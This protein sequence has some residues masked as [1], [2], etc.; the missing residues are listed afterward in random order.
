MALARHMLLSANQKNAEKRSAGRVL[1]MT[2]PN[3]TVRNSQSFACSPPKLLTYNPSSS[4]GDFKRICGEKLGIVCTRIF[5]LSGG[6]VDTCQQLEKDDVLICTSGEVFIAPTVKTFDTNIRAAQVQQEQLQQLQQQQQQQQQQQ[7]QLLLRQRNHSPPQGG[8]LVGALRGGGTGVAAPKAKPSNA[9][10]RFKSVVRRVQNQKQINGRHLGTT[11]R[12][13]MQHQHHPSTSVVPTSMIATSSNSN[14]NQSSSNQS[15]SNSTQGNH[16]MDI[17]T[18]HENNE[19]ASPNSNKNDS[20]FSSSK[21]NTT[22]DENKVYNSEAENFERRLS[23]DSVEG[24]RR[25]SIWDTDEI[26][27]SNFKAKRNIAKQ[28]TLKDENMFV[29]K[30]Q[31]CWDCIRS[32][33]IVMKGGTSVDD[34]VREV[35]ALPVIMPEHPYRMWWDGVLTL[36]VI[37]Y[38]LAVPLRIAFTLAQP[39]DGET[40]FDILVAFLFIMDIGLN[41]CTAIKVRGVYITEHKLIANY[42]LKSWFIIDFVSSMPIDLLFLGQ[43]EDDQGGAASSS[44]KM[45]KSLRI[46]KLLRV[47]RLQRIINRLET[48]H[49]VDPSLLR[50][51]KLVGILVTTWHWL[52]C[53]YW[54]IAESEYGT[55]N[56]VHDEWIP[57]PHVFQATSLGAQY[58]FAFFWAVVVTSGI[59][60]DII[61]N[62]TLQITFTTFAIVAGL[63]IYA[64]I[65]GSAST[66]LA[67]MDSVESDRKAKMNE[68]KSLLRNRHVPKV[69]S[70]EIYEFF[71]YLLSCNNSSID[72]YSILSELPQSL[73]SRLNIAIN[74]QIIKSIP[75]FCQCSDHAMALLIEQLYQLVILPGEYVMEQGMPGNEMYFVVRGKLQVLRDTKQGHRITM[76]KRSE[77][78][79]FGEIALFEDATQNKNLRWASVKALTYCDLLTLP[80]EGF[81]FVRKHFPSIVESMKTAAARRKE[82]IETVKAVV[83]ENQEHC[84]TISAQHAGKINNAFSSKITPDASFKPRLQPSRRDGS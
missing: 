18:G 68:V 66:L 43:S 49:H 69:L 53:F 82:T 36:L 44:L 35:C 71:E 46:F 83:L 41:F 74:R 38:S 33:F 22:Q 60:W 12:P 11:P 13:Q 67:N 1:L 61:P 73:R 65:I 20:F 80:R 8:S 75:I 31:L 27:M 62:T 23:L 2:M 54:G 9:L 79:F 40:I 58:A 47:L 29:Q 81:E 10:N 63:L 34:P 32:K 21:W 64:I 24:R 48:H 17:G 26:S 14:S 57:P 70:S 42:Y 30:I 84:E 3:Q 55:I 28:D 4:F 6:E 45:L 52:G 72:E 15:S 7:E 51:G 37:Y 39:S 5:V 19:T 59:G 76:A 50:M 77:G 25:S 16:I 78:E 56:H